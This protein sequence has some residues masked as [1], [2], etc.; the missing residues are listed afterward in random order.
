MEKLN[1]ILDVDGV[2]T[3]G[4]FLYS[5]E[6]KAFKIFGPHDGD[7]LK[8][9]KDKVNI[10]FISADKRGFGITEKR[11]KDMGFTVDLVPEADRLNW[12]KEK[13]G[14]ENTIFMGDGI[15]DAEIL[16]LC[17]LGIAPINA[18]KEAKAAAHFIT[19]SRSGEGAVC[20]ACL[21]VERLFLKETKKDDL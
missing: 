4:H 16:K 20:D 9:I 18:R 6:G 14:F 17:K 7:G 2:L 1:F 13:Y 19:E 11:I 12:F 15:F 5:I 3:T 21:E 8:K 10:K